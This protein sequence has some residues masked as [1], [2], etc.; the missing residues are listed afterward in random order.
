MPSRKDDPDTEHPSAAIDPKRTAAQVEGAG[1]DH[2]HPSTP[3]SPTTEQAPS[4]AEVIGRL[5][6]LW[7]G[8]PAE[9]QGPFASLAGTRVGPYVIERAIGRGGFGIV[10]KARDERVARDVALKIPRPEVLLD[11]EKL[12]RFEAEAT[13]TAQLDHPS[14]VPL[15]EAELAGATPYLAAA[16]CPGPNLRQWLNDNPEPRPGPAAAR[17]VVAL[18]EAV[19]YAHDQ[20]VFHRDLK[21][22]NV[23]LMPVPRNDDD[24]QREPFANRTGDG[25][26]PD[27]TPRSS[28]SGDRGTSL[29]DYLPRLTDF[30]LA[31]FSEN[32]MA[33]TQTSIRLGTPLYMA[34]EQ[35]I[36]RSS[37]RGPETDIYALGVLL[38][39]L[40]SGR[41]PFSGSS[42]FEIVQQILNVEPTAPDRLNKGI[43]RDLS[44]ICLKCLEK[45]PARRYIS[46]AELQ[47]DLLRYL[48]GQP[49]VARPV[50]A[51]TRGVRW[52]KRTP[53]VAALLLLSCVAVA[54]TVGGLSFH[55][56]TVNQQTT[57]LADAVVAVRGERET[58]R[59]AL[60]DA[61]AAR[62]NAELLRQE[63]RK[64]SY[65][66]DL[67]LAFQLFRSGHVV[68][69]RDLLKN[70]V[71]T[72][73][74]DLRGPEWFVLQADLDAATRV[75]GHLD[76]AV[77][78]CVVSPDG[79]KAYT[80][81]TDGYVRIWDLH[82]GRVIQR[83]HAM[84]G[85]IHA[86]ALS[87]DGATLAAG[88]MA[89]IVNAEVR[90]MDAATGQRRTSLQSHETTI[91]SIAFSRDGL[92]LAAGS[93]YQ[94]VQLTRL[95]DGVTRSLP[96]NRRNRMLSFSADSQW[97]AVGADTHRVDL[98]P[99][100]Q[101]TRSTP[102]EVPG[103]RTGKPYLAA[104]APHG[105]LLATSYTDRSF[106]SLFHQPDNRRQALAMERE[107]HSRSARLKSLG[108]SP[109]SQRLAAGDEAGSIVFW[110]LNNPSAD[111][112]EELEPAASFSPHEATVSA[113]Q[114]IDESNLISGGEDG[115]VCITSPFAHGGQHWRWRGVGVM[116]AMVT[117][118]QLFLGCDDGTVRRM[119]R[120]VP[121]RE[122]KQSVLAMPENRVQS[123][124]AP[125]IFV[126]TT[127]A[128]AC[129][130]VSPDGQ[131]MAT[132]SRRGGVLEFD[133]LS[134]RLLREIQPEANN[135]DAAV[136]DI[137]YSANG[138]LMAFAGRDRLVRILETDTGR[139]RLSHFIGN[140]IPL[141]FVDDDRRLA[142]GHGETLLDILDTDSGRLLRSID[143]ANV[144]DL[145]VSP[146]G[147][148]LACAQADSRLRLIDVVSG[149]ERIVPGQRRGIQSV[150]FSATGDTVI[151]LDYAGELRF[152]DATT[153]TAFGSVMLSDKLVS[154]FDHA[155]IVCEK[156]WLATIVS[157]VDDDGGKSSATDLYFWNLTQ[158]A[159]VRIAP[160]PPEA[161]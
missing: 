17:F 23:L 102:H 15:Y 105:S 103:Y 91:E 159:E 80:A 155:V 128:V 143:G 53:T 18:A 30:G 147:R 90:L 25:P 79:R 110:N 73:D 5:D 59:K 19:Q 156:S 127:S 86:L 100:E 83:Y 138:N 4:V 32:A 31:W 64:T 112:P 154:H 140:G 160:E 115:R 98:W 87:P 63:A 149:Q 104:F 22:G 81:G 137:S 56:H 1:S 10:Y 99:V 136:R 76:G 50:S 111:S 135:T 106:V 45:E 34:P 107:A 153:G 62:D 117:D 40:I 124:A 146:N 120:D 67:R 65:R 71:P 75:L 145:A 55:L 29:D 42:E 74:T 93:R 118:D 121:L 97:L 66:S 14:I 130:A 157:V 113:V 144:T 38:Y 101:E 85:E 52:A 33:A 119:D 139:V 84:I 108:F 54:A 61:E 132:G 13:A 58:A 94:P 133:C 114:F 43:A 158:P 47:A 123:I 46:A 131:R 96:A 7:A 148:L 150:K 11:D 72:D 27:S 77:T 35:A 92:W 26:A 69:V 39:E 36:G 151:S 3:H 95:A 49:T 126:S 125:D 2:D 109:D 6:R 78:E 51:F 48:H 88:G 44:S 129:L 134:G 9:T 21:P 57:A 122:P 89:L 28:V 161:H 8:T 141:Q 20:G 16:Y 68:A 70:Q 24:N 116:D 60:D 12:K 82:T 152:V 142:V 37:R 41:P